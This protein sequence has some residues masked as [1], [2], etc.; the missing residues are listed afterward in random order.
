MEI[1]LLNLNLSPVPNSEIYSVSMLINGEL[2]EGCLV[3][4]EKLVGVNYGEQRDDKI[5]EKD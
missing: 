4:K 5:N 3:K 1:K 2:Y